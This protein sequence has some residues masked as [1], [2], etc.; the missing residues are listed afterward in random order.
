MRALSLSLLV[1]GLAG[2]GGASAEL[3]LV[4]PT[5]VDRSVP[6]FARVD[7]SGAGMG[8][9]GL[10]GTLSAGEARQALEPRMSEMTGCFALRSMGF[11]QLGGQ[12]R[13]LIRVEG[14]GRVVSSHPEDSTVGDRDVERCVRRV[15]L[16][17]RFPRTHGG[18]EAEIHWAMTVDPPDSV[19]EPM[20]WS[21][22]RVARVV[23]L[24]RARGRSSC[25]LD[26]GVQVTV[27]VSRG[28]RVLR[29]GAAAAEATDDEVLD[30]VASRV[31]RWRMPS[32][33]HGAK[34]TFEIG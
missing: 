18:G 1:V 3:P 34:V 16:G 5:M 22:E 25:N 28:G 4:A 24:R 7:A 9:S 17:T 23:R 32:S 33:R 6:G 26:S 13:M 19:R 20:T 31:Q 10:H 15:I 21:P 30:C 12:I 8:V 14:S 11:E 2:C 29:A 27:Y